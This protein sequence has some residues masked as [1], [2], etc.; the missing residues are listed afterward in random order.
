MPLKINKHRSLV[1]KSRYLI[2]SE[3]F[4]LPAASLINEH[5][6]ATSGRILYLLMTS[7]TISSAMVVL[8]GL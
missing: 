7:V 1:I 5:V 8:H 3:S 4:C 2:V 6:N